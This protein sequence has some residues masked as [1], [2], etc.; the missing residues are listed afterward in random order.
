MSVR[1]GVSVRSWKHASNVLKANVDVMAHFVLA[2]SPWTQLKYLLQSM[3]YK[4]VSFHADGHGM[5][6]QRR[7]GVPTVTTTLQMQ[8]SPGVPTVT[9]TVS[10]RSVASRLV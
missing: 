9:L 4:Q 10:D 7:G 8:W 2:R 1:Q 3:K 6:S 5:E